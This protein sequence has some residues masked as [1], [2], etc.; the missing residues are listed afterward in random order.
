MVKPLLSR[1][2]AMQKEGGTVS[3]RIGKIAGEKGEHAELASGLV[4]SSAE[5][6]VLWCE[7]CF[8][9]VHCWTPAYRGSETLSSARDFIKK[10]A[11]LK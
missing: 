2:P 9:L 6:E 1:L 5:M 4:L 11:M 7:R 8:T 3:A 10:I